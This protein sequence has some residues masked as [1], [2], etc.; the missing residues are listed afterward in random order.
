MRLLLEYMY[1]GNIS[2]RQVDLEEVLR[3]A[4]SLKIRGLTTAEPPTSDDD[5]PRPLIVD[6]QFPASDVS[7]DKF[8]SVETLSSH[9]ATSGKSGSRKG[10]GRKSSVPK[11]LRLSGDR[12]SE[13]SSPRP[14]PHI[15]NDLRIS[16]LDQISGSS[17][18]RSPIDN[19]PVSDTEEIDTD[20]PVDFSTG[21]KIDIAPRYSILGSYLKTGR[22]STTPPEDLGYD[23]RRAELAED[24][25][26]AGYGGSPWLNSLEQLTSMRG[27]RPASRDSR[28]DSREERN[29]SGEDYEKEIKVRKHFHLVLKIL[30]TRCLFNI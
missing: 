19:L 23:L 29:S 3:T 30:A 22:S 10:E 6:E 24:L 4:S 11:K 12:E 15:E 27:P 18:N 14:W 26:R 7:G 2:V 21:G 9:S 5:T 1:R 13:M 28:G 25:R 17:E 16:S 20:Q 8:Q